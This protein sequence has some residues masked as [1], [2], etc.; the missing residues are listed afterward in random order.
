VASFDLDN[1]LSALP[2]FFVVSVRGIPDPRWEE[3]PR[4]LVVAHP[5]ASIEPGALREFL[6]ERVARFWV[7]EYWVLVS[8]LP[9]TSVGKIDKK[10]LRRLHAEGRFKIERA[11]S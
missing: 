7:P 6:R 8:E 9:K 1:L 11:L 4:A 3:R 5:G 2:D 10:E